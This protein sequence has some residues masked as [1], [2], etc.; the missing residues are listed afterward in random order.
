MRRSVAE[1]RRTLQQQPDGDQ[2]EEQA[3][4]VHPPDSL[5]RSGGAAGWV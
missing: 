2:Q 4:D 3:G 1:A 5:Q